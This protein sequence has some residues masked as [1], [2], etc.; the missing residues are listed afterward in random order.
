MPTKV[1]VSVDFSREKLDRRISVAPM[2]DWTDRHCRYFLRGFSADVLLYTE[3]ITAAA[4]L[5]GNRERLL[6]Y[7]PAEHPL[8]LQLGGSEPADLAAAARIGADFGYDEIN[9]N[10]GC[11]SDRVHSGAFGACLML[12]PARVADCVAAMHAA[13]R[14]PVTVKMRIGVVS[15]AGVAA[16]EAIARF[17]EGDAV[18]LMGFVDAVRDAGAAAVIVHARKAVL[19]GLSPKENR[20]VPPLRYQ[21]VRAVKQRNPDLPV[22]LNGGLREAGAVI[23]ALSWCDGVMLG[24]EAYHRPWLLHELHRA[25]GSG[26][27]APEPVR[28]AL[29]ERMAVYAARELARGERL[30]SITRHMLGLY[31]GE[32]GA[33]EYRRLLSEGARAPGAGA[34]LLRRAAK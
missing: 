11:P 2:M 14:L 33:R 1:G 30:P 19:G 21:V 4:I 31:A 26:T 17:S 32:P 27:A 34:E 24:R 12:E 9:L 8:A 5:R 6:A 7:D 22:I 28:G 29:L 23:A 10:C 16:R 25:L 3:M 20:E 15:G 13:V 18:A